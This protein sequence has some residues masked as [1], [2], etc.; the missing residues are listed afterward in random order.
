MPSSYNAAIFQVATYNMYN[1]FAIDQT[2][3]EYEMLLQKVEF[4]NGT[5]PD[6]GRATHKNLTNDAWRRIYDTQYVS[7]HGDLYLVMDRYAFESSQDSVSLSVSK[8]YPLEID[9]THENFRYVTSFNGESSA[10]WI[11]H[12]TFAGTSSQ[13]N[14]ATFYDEKAGPRLAHI[15]HGIAK[16]VSPESRL[17]VSLALM[18]IVIAFNFFKLIIMTWVLYTDRSAYIVTLGDAAASFL[19]RP[20]PTTQQQCMLGK[21]EMLF[22]LGHVPYLAPGSFREMESFSLRSQGTWLPQRRDNFFVLGR[23]RQ[24]FF[25]LL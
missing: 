10:G 19:E 1:L 24:I 12:L 8:Y 21:E 20:D 2:S 3:A 7:E 18:L 16:K 13:S 14:N 11:N 5:A 9:G 23:D 22:R 4:P 25:M 17:Q 6:G 15:T